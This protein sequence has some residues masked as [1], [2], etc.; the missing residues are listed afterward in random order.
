MVRPQGLVL[1]GEPYWITPPT[2]EA[3]DAMGHGFTSL[4]GTVERF[5]AAGAELVEMV[6]A[7]PD[8]WDRYMAGQ[9]WTVSQWLREHPDH[10]D[11]EGMQEFLDSRRTSHLTYGRERFGWGVFVLRLTR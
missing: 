1:I 6:M 7:D 3:E 9:W 4:I 10:P 5:N 8:S 11:H 2:P